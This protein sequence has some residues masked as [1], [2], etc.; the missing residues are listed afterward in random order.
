MI[1]ITKSSDPLLVTTLTTVIYG[2]P[3]CGKSSTAFTADSPLVLDFDAGAYRSQFR[4][5]TVQVA[6]WADVDSI[7]E[8]DLKPYATVVLDTVGRALDV[9]TA[10]LIAKNPKFKGYGGALSLQGYGAL[11]STFVSWLKL[12]HSYHKDVVLLAHMDEQRSGDEIVERLDVQGGSKG[13]IYKCA[14]AMG[15]LQFVGGKR[16]LNFSPSDTAFGKNPAQ[17]SPIPVPDFHTEPLFL[18]EVLKSIKGKLNEA[19]AS[20]LAEQARL[21]E[22]KASFE[23]LST[24]EQ[25]TEKSVELAKAEPKIK[26]LLLAV[27]ETKGFSFNKKEKAFATRA[28]AA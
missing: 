14:D 12:L 19:S 20:S 27:A 23:H 18:A 6:D 2:P 15:R 11:K 3:G 7:T 8:S 17:L 24:P 9:L 1:K 10:A 13:E 28:V 22:F 21:D 5:D 26:A 16:V 4:K 25:F